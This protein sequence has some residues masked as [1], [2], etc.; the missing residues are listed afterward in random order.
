MEEVSAPRYEVADVLKSYGHRFRAQYKLPAHHLRTLRALGQCR[1]AAL[2]GHVDKC[3][4][5]GEV[6]ISYNSCRNRHCPKCQNTNREQWLMDREAELLPVP[7]FHLVFTL[8]HALNGLCM[9]HPKAMYGMLFKAA[10][11]TVEGFG[12]NP[13]ML[14]AETG[15]TAILHTWATLEIQLIFQSIL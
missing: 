3:T 15:M 2:G 14:G 10:W 8:P 12:W 1:T 6:R 4:S 7:Y 9:H 5:C 13:K 11:Q